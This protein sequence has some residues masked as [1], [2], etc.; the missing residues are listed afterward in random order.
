MTRL[1][2]QLAELAC[3]DELTA[4]PNRRAWEE[5]LPRDQRQARRDGRALC[6][7]MLDLD[8]FKAYNDR[9]GHR[10]GDRLLKQVSAAWSGQLRGGDV[11]ARYGG[12]EFALALPGCPI[13]FAHALVQR[14]RL[15][16]PDCATC[17]I[18]VAEW[19]GQESGDDLVERAD[20]ALYE[21]KA[22]GR[23]RV[24]LARDLTA[25]AA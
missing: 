5:V 19:D 3:T 7:A 15:A 20:A 16:M 1:V 21:A 13:G 11:L 2:A 18:G 17:S 4:L 25:K 22:L 10:S 14:L 24:V 9:H 12:E 6:V 23:N 8:N